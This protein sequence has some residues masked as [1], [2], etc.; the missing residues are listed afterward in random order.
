MFPVSLPR[1]TRNLGTST[2]TATAQNRYV[3][4]FLDAVQRLKSGPNNS[5]EFQPS[6]LHRFK[7]VGYQDRQ[8]TTYTLEYRQTKLHTTHNTN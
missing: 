2:V 3:F 8:L 4:L 5:V 7:T 6:T 1:S